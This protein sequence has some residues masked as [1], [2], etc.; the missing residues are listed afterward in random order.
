MFYAHSCREVRPVFTPTLQ[1]GQQKDETNLEVLE[2]KPVQC[3]FPGH[4]L[5]CHSTQRRSQIHLGEMSHLGVL[6]QRRS[7]GMKLENASS[8]NCPS[9]VAGVHLSLPGCL[10]PLGSALHWVHLVFKSKN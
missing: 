4:T 5:Q 2:P 9:G 1:M 3:E 10:L 7:G 8:R 6:G